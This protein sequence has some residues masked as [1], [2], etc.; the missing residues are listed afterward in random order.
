MGE[1]HPVER[2]VVFEDRAEVTRRVSLPSAPGRHHVR[3]GP[4]SP[5]IRQ[6][7]LAFVAE[8]A[9]VE[10]VSIH[11]ERL[12]REDADGPAAQALQAE[13]SALHA[14]RQAVEAALLADQGAD[15]RARARL[16]VA[17]A[18]SGQAL[19]EQDDAVAWVA[20]VRALA[21]EASAS[22]GHR[23]ALEA[24]LIALSAEI[25][26]LRQRLQLARGGAS[27]L[28]AW[29]DL[30]VRISGEDPQLRVRTVLPCAAWR[31]IHQASLTGAR[32]AWETGA[33]V[34]NATG[35]AWAGV[36]LVCSTARAST[37]AAPPT[38]TD[39]RIETRPRDKEVVVQARDEAVVQARVGAAR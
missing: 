23:A 26:A 5:L 39:D 21:D 38:L 17:R 3:V 37:P 15:A 31:P 30:T 7:A 35:E 4:L 36:E 24:D 12:S 1:P 20:A 32:L 25:D 19:Q 11:R 34:W 9:V 6:A 16:E 18:W 27:V 14:Q 29:L 22:V 10:S 28:R 2:V 33:M 13:L 8:G